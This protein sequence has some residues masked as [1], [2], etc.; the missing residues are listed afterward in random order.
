MKTP[1]HSGCPDRPGAV[2]VGWRFDR[3]RAN[4]ILGD[5]GSHMIDLA[6]CCTGEVTRVSDHLHAYVDHPG[7]TS[8]PTRPTTVRICFS[9]SQAVREVTCTSMPSPTLPA[10]EGGPVH[11]HGRRGWY[12]GMGPPCGL[13]SARC[14]ASDAEFADLQTSS[15]GPFRQLATIPR[16]E[17]AGD[18]HFIESILDNT[19]PE[20]NFLDGLR[21]QKVMDAALLSSQE[22]CSVAVG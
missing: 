8:D 6:R 16:E 20:P 14:L 2:R 19:I 3:A 15:D 4:G 10:A 9:S 13:R 1:G 21:V 18:R 11:P 5:M 17:A 12:P 22:G 7:R